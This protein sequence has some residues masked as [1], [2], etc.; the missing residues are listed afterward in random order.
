MFAKYVVSWWVQQQKEIFFM[1]GCSGEAF[2][3]SKVP[4]TPVLTLK[5]HFK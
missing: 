4:N 2:F 1:S 5:T 3:N